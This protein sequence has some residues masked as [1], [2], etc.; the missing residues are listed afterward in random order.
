M[1]K[2]LFRVHRRT[3]R[4]SGDYSYQGSRIYD[5]QSSSAIAR[6]VLPAYS[7]V[8][9]Q[10]GVN[11]GKYSASLFAKNVGNARGLT[12]AAPLSLGRSL[13]NYTVTLIQPL[14]VGVS[15]AD[16]F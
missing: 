6:P 10:V 9:L 4:I 3:G 1:S 15:L 7:V 14:T 12:S 16:K 2:R 13:D 5:F 11:N 8:N